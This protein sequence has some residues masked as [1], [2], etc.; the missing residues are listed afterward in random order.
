MGTPCLPVT[1]AYDSRT[2]QPLQGSVGVCKAQP[3]IRVTLDL[4]NGTRKP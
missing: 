2:R 3:Y 4:E 1:V